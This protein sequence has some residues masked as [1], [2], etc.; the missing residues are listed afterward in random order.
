[1][2]N[3]SGVID[4]ARMISAWSL[5]TLKQ[6]QRVIDPTETNFDYFQSD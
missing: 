1:M 4:P 6:F 3:F 2:Q 5:K